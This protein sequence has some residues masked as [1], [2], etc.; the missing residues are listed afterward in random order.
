MQI[1]GEYYINQYGGNLRYLI[2]LYQS[3]N[4]WI[5]I[6]ETRSSSWIDLEY[7]IFEA[8]VLAFQN[9][10][11]FHMWRLCCEQIVSAA[12]IPKFVVQINRS[13]RIFSGQLWFHELH[14][15]A[16]KMK[17]SWKFPDNYDGV[18]TELEI[19]SKFI[20]YLWNFIVHIEISGFTGLTK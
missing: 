2:T 20:T 14:Q 16:R 10:R 17:V 8:G 5:G 7:F 4:L 18:L 1:V 6:S 9:C 3:D 15:R 19:V 12:G 13:F 11:E